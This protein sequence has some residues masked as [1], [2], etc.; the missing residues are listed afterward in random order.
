MLHQAAV[1]VGCAGAIHPIL[2][3]RES[4]KAS[5][6]RTGW[7]RNWSVPAWQ[8]QWRSPM[9]DQL[10]HI[11]YTRV[12]EPQSW[13]H[14]KWVPKLQQEFQGAWRTFWQSVADPE[15]QAEYQRQVTLCCQKPGFAEQP[16]RNLI[17]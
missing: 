17:S 15:Y 12:R 1:R 10:A 11:S 2:A 9:N 8:K 13:D 7:I 5:I 16:I 4:L 14:T 6:A 3:S